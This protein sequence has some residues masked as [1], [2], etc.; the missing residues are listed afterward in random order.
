MILLNVIVLAVALLVLMPVIFLAIEIAVAALP[1][2]RLV[3]SE[4]IESGTVAPRLAVLVPAHN[5]ASIIADTINSLQAVLAFDDRV[6]IVADNCTDDTA[7]KAAISRA[8]VIERTDADLRGKGYALDFGVRHLANDPP[9][10]VIIF[11]ADC[12]IDMASIKRIT[13]IAAVSGRPVQARYH[14]E[15]PATETHSPKQLI[16][17]FAWWLKLTLRQTG[18][19]NLGLPCQL[20]GTGMAFPWAIISQMPLRT[21]EIVEDLTLGLNLA[22]QGKGALF[23]ADAQVVS[24]F[25]QSEQGQS[26]QRTRWETGH[27]QAIVRH[28]PR[29]IMNGIRRGHLGAIGLALDVAVPPLAFLALMITLVGLVSCFLAIVGGW[30]LPLVVAISAAIIFSGAV[31]AAWF[32]GGRHVISARDLLAVPGYVL[33]KLGVYGHALR[34]GRVAWIKT[35]RD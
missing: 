15:L 30:A 24:T 26:S 27:L 34:G 16:A 7:A 4:A 33:S 1:A 3:G 21:S 29:V 8:E 25:P 17:A 9:D 32:M 18:L 22:A 5:E 11:D 10:V 14:M 12:T 2:R 31:L 6:V 23:C 20:S 35:K 28:V 13:A 19:A